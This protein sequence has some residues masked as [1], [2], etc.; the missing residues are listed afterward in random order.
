MLLSI[1]AL[2]LGL[3]FL[4]MNGV[5]GRKIISVWHPYCLFIAS[6]SLTSWLVATCFGFDPVTTRLLNLK[7]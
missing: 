4:T 6:L 5:V 3:C 1:E 7:T 2:D